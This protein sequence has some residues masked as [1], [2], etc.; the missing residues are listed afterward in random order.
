MEIVANCIGWYFSSNLS[1]NS[2]VHQF[3]VDVDMDKAAER[4]SQGSFPFLEVE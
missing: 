3:S 1:N 2:V 4:G